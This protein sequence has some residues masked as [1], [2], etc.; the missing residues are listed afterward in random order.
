MLTEGELGDVA[1]DDWDLGDVDWGANA[2]DNNNNPNH[3]P[4]REEEGAAA[5]TGVQEQEQEQGFS[6]GK[7][8]GAI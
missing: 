2:D 5:A 4:D 7:V 1:E 8:S 3:H 6:L